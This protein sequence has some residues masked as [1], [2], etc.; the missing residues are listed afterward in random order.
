MG[1][2][3]NPYIEGKENILKGNNKAI[4]DWIF[5][6]YLFDIPHPTPLSLS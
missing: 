4:H 5:D 3:I 2:K 1:D 6:I